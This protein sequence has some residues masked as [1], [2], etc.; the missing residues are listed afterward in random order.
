MYL[1]RP[2]SPTSTTPASF[3]PR[4]PCISSRSSSL[5]LSS[6]PLSENRKRNIGG[7][8]SLAFW[9]VS[10]VVAALFIPP[11]ENSLQERSD[12]PSQLL[13]RDSA[14]H[15]DE[16]RG[17]IRTRVVPQTRRQWPAVVVARR[18]RRRGRRRRRRPTPPLFPTDRSVSVVFVAPTSVVVL[19][20]IPPPPLLLLLPAVRHDRG[21]DR[22][23]RSRGYESARAQISP[24]VPPSSQPRGAD[25][26]AHRSRIGVIETRQGDVPRHV[27]RPGRGVG[28]AAGGGQQMPHGVQRERR[29]ERLDGGDCHGES[30]DRGVLRKYGRRAGGM[31]EL[32]QDTR[33]RGTIEVD[34]G[35]GD[36][37]EGEGIQEE[38]QGLGG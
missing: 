36:E 3:S 37:S 34:Q 29:S 24:P 13:V 5:S 38:I 16:K 32:P 20:P 31:P 2:R 6:F 11:P 17:S 25:R 12:A 28:G 26:G 33:G 18:G 23:R 27:R 30:Q 4:S 35:R 9:F 15:D 10:G 7:N 8:R 22:S 19:P 1:A 21:R 14:L